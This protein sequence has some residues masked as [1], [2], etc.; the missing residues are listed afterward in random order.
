MTTHPFEVLG[1]PLAAV[2]RRALSQAWYSALHLARS[3]SSP[4]GAGTRSSAPAGPAAAAHA[5]ASAGR[6]AVARRVVPLPARA[7]RRAGLQRSE[8]AFAQ[9]RATPA[10]L[11]RRIARGL[12][13]RAASGRRLSFTV[14]AAGARV[15]LVVAATP[16]GVRVVA[17]CPAG[18][19]RA[20]ERAL[21]HARFALAARGI[22]V[23]ECS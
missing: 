19:R 6:G 3:H 20:V 8:S 23:T 15:H 21:A 2:D 4:A 14:G 16:R 11:A 1:A 12:L 5:A 9:R 22:E 7:V 10:P 18:V 17:L 13:A